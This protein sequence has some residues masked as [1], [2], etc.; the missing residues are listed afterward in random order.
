MASSS[1][2]IIANEISRACKEHA[3]RIAVVCGT[4]QLPY[5][6]LEE[7]AIESSNAIRAILG[8]GRCNVGLYL[9]N[10]IEFPILYVGILYAGY[11]PFLIDPAFNTS[12]LHAIRDDCA[13]HT[14]LGKSD[15]MEK[16]GGR[17]TNLGY[18]LSLVQFNPQSVTQVT[19][20][21]DT[22]VCRFTSGTTGRPKC[23]EYSGKAVVS[24]A[25][26][27]I[28]GTSLGRDDRILC[29]A[30]LSNGL[31]FN[32]SFLAAFMV[33]ARL[34]L[35]KEFPLSRS[36]DRL[37]KIHSITRL[38]AYPTLYRLL[39]ESP[40]NL[41][42]ITQLKLAVSAGAP[43]WDDV[44]NAF[45]L[46]FKVGISDYYGIAETGP[47]TFER[48]LNYKDGLGEPLPGV[49]IH[50][51]QPNSAGIGA[52]LVRTQSR[53]SRYLNYSNL[54]EG[55]LDTKGFYQSG[56]F[57]FLKDGRLHLIRRM[58]THVNVGGRKVDPV[59]V[60]NVVMKMIGVREACAFADIDDKQETLLHLVVAADPL[61]TA[62]KI[63][64]TCGESL[65]TFKIP[66]RI[67]FVD[68]LPKNG[69]GKIRFNALVAEYGSRQLTN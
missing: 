42:A 10:C 13:V 19:P 3:N 41:T 30:A 64:S 50:I 68:E 46:R 44:R 59:E 22:E 29:M 31:A 32:T 15:L 63:R 26:N 37:I 40:D 18:G 67:T 61:V 11:V 7:R 52:V 2:G 36:I 14:L 16:L 34:C 20:L 4:E 60:A 5:S 65:A 62:E 54:L 21:Q 69:I 39:T 51:A 1:L 66:S 48:D 8:V 45:R 49:D 25:H 28:T 33:G 9:N 53:A 56:D 23:L 35:S 6:Q 47:C 27:W 38:V 24:A 12:E 17:C 55:C 43:L 58:G 57:G